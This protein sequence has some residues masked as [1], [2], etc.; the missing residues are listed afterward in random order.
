YSLAGLKS[1]EGVVFAVAVLAS[2]EVWWLRLEDNRFVR[3]ESYLREPTE[4]RRLGFG[5][6]HTPSTS[7]GLGAGEKLSEAA[8]V[9]GSVLRSVFAEATITGNFFE[10]LTAAGVVLADTGHVRL[11]R[12][13]VRE[14]HAGFWLSGSGFAAEGSTTETI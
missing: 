12:N 9:G 8:V 6:L 7:V 2:S 10:G 3:E 4:G 13:E 5:Y 14:S 11:I 1:E